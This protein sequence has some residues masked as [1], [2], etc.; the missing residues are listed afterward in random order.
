MR[1]IW[2]SFSVTLFFT[3]LLFTSLGTFVFAQTSPPDVAT[4][5]QAT[6]VINFS[7][8]PLIDPVGQPNSQRI[9]SQSYTASGTTTQVAQKVR[10][11][12]QQK[13]LRELDGAAYTEDYCSANFEHKGFR[14]SLS[15][16]PSGRPGQVLVNLQNHG[17]VD[18]A[19]LPVP[20]HFAL[21]YSLPAVTAY[22]TDRSVEEAKAE[23]KQLLEA[24]GWQGFGDTAVSFFMKKNAVRLQVMAT[25]APAQGGKTSV[26]LSSEQ[27]SVD[28]PVPP[29]L[30]W[31]QY[32][33]TTAGMQFRSRESQKGL[34][35]FFKNALSEQGWK[36]TT[37]SLVK[38]GF[39][40]SLIF[41]NSAAEMMEVTF[42]EVD[43][44]VNGNL[45]FQSADDF[46]AVDQ[47]VNAKV[48]EAQR[49]LAM[50]EERKKNPPTLKLPT[51]PNARVQVNMPQR[52]ELVA[53]SG[54]AKE[55]VKP[56]IGKR[57]AEG[58]KHKA[59]V[60][61]NEVGEH[62]LSKDGATLT[63]SIVDPGFIPAQIT[64]SV[65]GQF[66]LELTR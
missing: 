26:Q 42:S 38:V 48:A 34:V 37:D 51:L 47:R 32:A 58:W 15:V 20:P 41:R 36:P 31:L 45:R 35:D 22:T 49:E 16:T 43:G 10:E 4:A 33:D 39:R 18:L 24:Q 29:Q 57:V 23:C 11:A 8:L 60:D 6:E 17:N 54:T 14:I 30:E 56:W 12:L 59:I 50:E 5:K 52:V 46:A 62:S 28:L 7:T 64:I 2:R 53:G 65:Q 63:I 66:K 9:A 1:N 61:S 3:S 13:G 27:L 40:E 44:L 21:L 19:K 25:Q 55:I